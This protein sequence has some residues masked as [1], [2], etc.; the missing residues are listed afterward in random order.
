MPSLTAAISVALA[1]LVAAGVGRSAIRA[2]QQP[3]QKPPQTVAGR[4]AQPAPKSTPAA[5][6]RNFGTD[7]VY[8]YC[9]GCHDNNQHEADLSLEAIVKDNVAEHADVWEKVVKKLRTRQMPPIGEERP[10]DAYYD[11]AVA[12]LET[13]LDRAAAAEAEPRPHSDHPPADAHR[14][15]ERDPRF[16]RARRGRRHAITR[17]RVELRI[18]QRDGGRSV[19][20]ASGTLHLRGGENQPARR[21]TSEPLARRRYDQ[22]PA[23]LDA[24]RTHR[25]PADRHARRRGGL[26]HVSPGRRVRNPGPVEARPGR[27]S[28]RPE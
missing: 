24:G 3:A 13:T 19:A 8:D 20:D 22:N 18:R 15:S 6:S 23:G 2:E 21:G 17:R 16:A 1:G 26:L 25:G 9:L 7:I 4:S 27:K 5:A 14:I 11:A 12:S 10:D 28:G